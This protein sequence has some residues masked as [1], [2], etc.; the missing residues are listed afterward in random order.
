MYLI[1]ANIIFIL[2]ALIEG[3]REGFYWFFKANSRRQSEFEIHPVFA[4]QRG[5]V[6]VLIALNVFMFTDILSASLNFLSNALLFSFFHNGCYYLTR[7]KLDSKV[8]PLKWKDDSKTST[9]LTTKIFTYRNR[10]IC[11]VIGLVITVLS[12]LLIK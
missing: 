12:I 7:N 3:F 4:V 5:L 6:L 2:Y 1:I 8:Y 9:A 11:A 10:T